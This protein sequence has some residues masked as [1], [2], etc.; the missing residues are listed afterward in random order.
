[1]K[2]SF[3]V[4]GIPA[5][6]GSKTAFRH[7]KTGKIIVRDSCERNKS[8]R[9]RVA[10]TAREEYQREPM[11]GPLS[12]L[13]EFTMPRPKSHY[14][15]GRN[16]GRVRDCA[17]SGHTVKPD[18]TKLWRAAED[19]LTGILWA[20]DAQIVKQVVIKQYGERP[21]LWIGVEEVDG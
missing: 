2:V 11:K 20:D 16:A 10:W 6:G 8:W 13:A 1:M 5:P 21:G 3:F 14:G 17:P 7:N 9:E 12:I 15:T 18:A 4:S 19:A